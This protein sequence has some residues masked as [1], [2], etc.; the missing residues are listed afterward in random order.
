TPQNVKLLA[1]NL[2]RHT[3]GEARTWKRVPADETFGQ[4]QLAPEGPHLIL[5]QLAQGL[6]QLEVHAFGQATDVV[7][8]LDRHRRAAREGNALDHVRVKRTLGQELGP[9]EL[10]RLL[11]EHIYEEPPD[12]L[13]LGFGVAHAFERAQERILGPHMH[14]RDVVVL[15]E[16]R[17]D[18][19][20]LSLPQQAVVDKDAGELVIDGL[21]DEHGSDG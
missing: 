11:L 12:R 21:V 6:D 13:A 15:P 7:V 3:N 9:A 4:P 1:C 18:L 14:E 2:S 19:V 10:A 17:Y 8:R 5:E 16:Q 20:G